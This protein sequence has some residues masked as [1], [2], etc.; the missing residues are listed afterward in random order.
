MNDSRNDRIAASDDVRAWTVVGSMIAVL[1]LAGAFALG[2]WNYAGDIPP[3]AVLA[4][5]WQSW[6]VHENAPA[7]IDVAKRR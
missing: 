5:D 3:E 7:E 1:L 6:V 2:N 4:G